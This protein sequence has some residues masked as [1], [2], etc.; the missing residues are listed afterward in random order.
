[1]AEHHMWGFDS[2]QKLDT[3]DER[4]VRLVNDTLKAAPF[5]VKVVWGYR[6]KEAQEMA[7]VSGFSTKRWPESLHNHKPCRAVDLAPI[8]NGRIPW[9]DPRPWLLLAG[10]M[11]G[12]AQVARIPIRWGGNWDRD[13]VILDDQGLDDL[14]HFE[15]V[16]K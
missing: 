6:D 13:E 12:V 5:D 9:K 16:D 15:L 4:L 10:V 7:F 3:L 11:Y 14:G 8:V 2:K 1:M